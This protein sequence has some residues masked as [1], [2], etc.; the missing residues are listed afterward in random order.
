MLQR[1]DSLVIHHLC[2]VDLGFEYETLCVHQDMA[3]TALDLLASVV[4][5]LCSAPTAVL[6]TDWLSTMPALG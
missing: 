2:A 4:T 6:L 5:A 1:L 3:L